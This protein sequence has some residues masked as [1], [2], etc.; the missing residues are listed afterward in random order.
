MSNDLCVWAKKK[1]EFERG[2][3]MEGGCLGPDDKVTGPNVH[4]VTKGALLMQLSLSMR[5]YGI[6]FAGAAM[7]GLKQWFAS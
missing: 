4:I 6:K 3:V 5:D 2:T 7:L 1:L